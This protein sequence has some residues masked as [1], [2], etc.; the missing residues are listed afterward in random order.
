MEHVGRR[1]RVCWHL[2][3]PGE[4]EWF[5]G[6][7]TQYDGKT[8]RHEISYDLRGTD[9]KRRHWVNLDALFFEWSSEA[10]E[11]MRNLGR[12]MSVED[13][14]KL[15][16]WGK[17]IVRGKCDAGW[18]WLACEVGRLT[19]LERECNKPGNQPW[20]V[21]ALALKVLK[22]YPLCV[23]NKGHTGVDK[24][25]VIAALRRLPD[26]KGTAKD[27]HAEIEKTYGGSGRLDETIASST[28]TIP[29]W[30]NVTSMILA[31]NPL[32]FHKSKVAGKRCLF[33]LR[34]DIDESSL[35]QPKK[36]R[37]VSSSIEKKQL[38]YVRAFGAMGGR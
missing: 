16:K 8:D 30:K 17:R 9:G 24:S 29:R 5:R 37:R 36:R 15:K 34:D 14:Q 20:R 10:Q 38:N 12:S 27:V 1:I 6:W 26:E 7:V 22:G 21:Q 18:P 33:Q 28:K 11:C 2:L 25:V 13:K 32:L 23:K 3:S 19:R 31:S 4:F 35:A